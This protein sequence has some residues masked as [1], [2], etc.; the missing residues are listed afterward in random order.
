MKYHLA[1]VAL[2]LVIVVFNVPSSKADMI[3]TLNQ[4]L[5]NQMRLCSQ[6]RDQMAKPDLDSLERTR[7]QQSLTFVKIFYCFFALI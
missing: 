3:D 1:L 7:L 2:T 6:I 5:E 4:A